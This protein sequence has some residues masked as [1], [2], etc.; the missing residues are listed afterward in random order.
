MNQAINDPQ[1]G[2]PGSDRI[3]LHPLCEEDFPWLLLWMVQETN[4]S[5][6]LLLQTTKGSAEI[7]IITGVINNHERVSLL[8]VYAAAFTRLKTAY[9][10]QPGEYSI[11]QLQLNPLILNKKTVLFSLLGHYTHYLFTRLK[12]NKIFWEIPNIDVLYHEL[13]QKAGFRKTAIQ[14]QRLYTLYEY[15]G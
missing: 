3:S 2:P 7:T 10:L 4:A 13:A 6:A 11:Q 15:A 1:N 14:D 5:L 9:T 8:T 12:A